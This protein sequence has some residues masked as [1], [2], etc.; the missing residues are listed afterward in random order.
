MDLRVSDTLG[1]T[2]FP[3]LNTII[4]AKIYTPIHPHPIH[5]Y[6]VLLSNFQLRFVFFLRGPRS[7]LDGRAQTDVQGEIDPDRSTGGR[8][9]L[10]EKGEYLAHQFS[11]ERT[12]KCAEQEDCNYKN[13]ISPKCLRCC[14]FFFP[15]L[16][17]RFPH[18]QFTPPGA[19]VAKHF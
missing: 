5:L 2:N 17:R 12:R 4:F 11:T 18:N 14:S 7:E 13:V 19:S 8:Y 1:C 16:H 9:A 10:E 15:T 3:S 6:T